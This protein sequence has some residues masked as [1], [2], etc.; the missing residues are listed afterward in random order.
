MQAAAHRESSVPFPITKPPPWN[1][2]TPTRPS[3]LVLAVVGCHMSKP[4][5]RL[6]DHSDIVESIH[7]DDVGDGAGGSARFW[8]ANP[9][10]AS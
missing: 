4:I 8:S 2:I 9:S 1:T 5:F 7:L 6:P 3:P 10:E